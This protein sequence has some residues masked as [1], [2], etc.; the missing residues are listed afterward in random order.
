MDVFFGF[1]GEELLAWAE[2]VLAK[3]EDVLAK[4]EEVL[5][6]GG[7]LVEAISWAEE[8]FC[9]GGVEIIGDI[10]VVEC[11][12]LLLVVRFVGVDVEFVSTASGCLVGVDIEISFKVSG[13]VGS[14]ISG[15]WWLWISGVW[16]LSGVF[17]MVG[18]TSGIRK[19][20]DAEEVT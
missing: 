17:S 2:E 19:T 14:G 6:L 18:R 5:C 4:A 11:R 16:G 1:R 8:F 20:R 9:L 15:V 13:I 7:V 10:V 12:R 3:A